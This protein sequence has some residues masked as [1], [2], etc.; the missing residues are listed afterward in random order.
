MKILFP[1]TSAQT[2][3][4]KVCPGS[5]IALSYDGSMKKSRDS[6]PMISAATHCTKVSKQKLQKSI[7]P[8]FK[9]LRAKQSDKKHPN[10]NAARTNANAP[11]LVSTVGVQDRYRCRSEPHT[12]HET[13]RWHFNDAPL[14]FA[15]R[16]PKGCRL[17]VVKQ[18]YWVSIE[19]RDSNNDHS[20]LQTMF[21]PADCSLSHS[22]IISAP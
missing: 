21:L 20:M 18:A 13:P 10:A 3:P 1:N 4:A 14:P 16:A 11:C 6:V 15:S 12:V 7:L 9:T 8:R 5:R 19:Q 17:S 2:K 22:A